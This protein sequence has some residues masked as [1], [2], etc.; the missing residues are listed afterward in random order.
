MELFHKGA[1]RKDAI[2]YRDVDTA[3]RLDVVLFIA[4]DTRWE[5][6]PTMFVMDLD[7]TA[8]Q[9]TAA[10]KLGGLVGIDMSPRPS[11]HRASY[12]G[13]C[14]HDTDLC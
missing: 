7:S 5:T 3:E 1:N 2:R 8:A 9:G 13:K 11:K 6:V 10:T 4:S 12:P 14:N